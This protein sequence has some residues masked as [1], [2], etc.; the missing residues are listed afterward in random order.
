MVREGCSD[1]PE[2]GSANNVN[3]PLTIQTAAGPVTAEIE[4]TVETDTP[5]IEAMIQR[6]EKPKP[7]LN[8]LAAD[9][10]KAFRANFAQGGRPAWAANAASTIA[11][12]TG[13]GL[14]ARTKKGN[15]PWRL[16]QNGGFG[17]SNS[18]LIMTGALR[19]SYATKNG[20]G[21]VE[22]I[23]EAN[24]TV[25]VGS[26]LKTKKGAPLA[27]YM[28]GGAKP[29]T[30]SN[31]FGR[32]IVVHHPGYPARP[33]TVTDEDAGRMSQTMLNYIIGEQATASEG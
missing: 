33:Q 18:V 6:M 26:N 28:Q 7:L 13:M 20:R 21:H 30:I 15:I 31:A 16:K 25:S 17:G 22:V 9:L 12:K 1:I 2:H 32:G 24:G 10:R 14:P 8:L 3:I 29:F 5:Q 19:D 4:V 27:V 23:D 11:R